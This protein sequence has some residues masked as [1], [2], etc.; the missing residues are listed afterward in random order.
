K[1]GALPPIQAVET[2]GFETAERVKYSVFFRRHRRSF[3]AFLLGSILASLVVTESWPDTYRARTVLEVMG[4]NEDFMNSRDLN[5][6]TAV[7]T[8]DTFIETQTKLL[9]SESIADR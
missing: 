5:P 4:V 9:Q 8:P 2:P 3:V 6:N 1:F 7:V